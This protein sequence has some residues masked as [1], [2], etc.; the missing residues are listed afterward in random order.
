MRGLA[1]SSAKPMMYFAPQPN[2]LKKLGADP[3]LWG[4]ITTPA[5]GARPILPGYRWIADNGCFTGVWKEW[6]W[7]EWLD[8]LAGCRRRCVMATLPDVVG[9]P[10]QTMVSFRHY[11]PIV[12]QRGWPV[13]LVAQDGME[14]LPWPT[15]YD[16]LFI[17]GGTEWK[18]S[19]G[20]AWCIRRAQRDGKWTHVG[21]VNSIKRLAHFKLLGVNSVDGTTICF[22][23]EKRF[24]KLSE[25]LALPSSFTPE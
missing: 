17:G 25:A 24:H 15:D 18:L 22:A 1:L 19:E 13:G 11:L 16:A 7:L 4:L 12:R 23:P 14:E 21:R 5:R 8:V 20:A 3:A 9:D 6:A 2:V 10:V